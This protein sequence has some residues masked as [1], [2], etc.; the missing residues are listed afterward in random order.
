M[1][2]NV[3]SAPGLER[4]R[5][6]GVPVQVLSHRNFSTREAFDLALVELLKTRQIDLVC[7]AGFMRVLGATFCQAFPWA[8]LNVHPSL[9]PAFR[10]A[11]AQRQ[12]LEY[13]VKVT[14]ATVHF[15]TDELDAGPIV[16][17]RS[18]TVSEGDSAETLAERVLAVEREIYAQAVERV[19]HEPWIVV[20]RRVTFRPSEGVR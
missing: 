19:L 18:V 1:V 7:L 20:G 8:I 10:G 12:A 11:E 6:A 3:A 16:M 13:G 17:Q 15:V 2:S 9:L 5:T 14:G 4:A